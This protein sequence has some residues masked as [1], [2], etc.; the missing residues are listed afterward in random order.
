MLPC[1]VILM[2]EM[3]APCT[4]GRLE[5]CRL[6]VQLTPG[7]TVM[8]DGRLVGVLVPALGLPENGAVLKVQIHAVPQKDRGHD[9]P[10][11]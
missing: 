6:C 7:I 8:P 4:S 3:L 11:P 2:C 5:T 9:V 10:A 1:P